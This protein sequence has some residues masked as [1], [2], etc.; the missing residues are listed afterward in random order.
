MAVADRAWFCPPVD[1]ALAGDDVHVWRAALDQPDPLVK[2]LARTLSGDEWARVERYRFERDRRRFIVA[3]GVLRMILG[4][5]LD[6][7]PGRL[8]FGYEPH[9]KPYLADG[10][11][12]G[13]LQFN[14]SHSHELALYAFAHGRR[15]GVD[16]EYQRFVPDAE[17]IV[18][19][20]FSAR[21]KAM[22]RTLRTSQRQEAFLHWWTRKEAYGKAL[23]DGL[24]QRLD[25]FGVSLAPGE[26]ARLLGTAGD[27]ESAFHWS[28][29]SLTPARG[30]KAALAVEGHDWYLCFWQ[31]QPP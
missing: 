9:G 22:W 26:S 10:F 16:L 3:R 28:L 2:Q 1:L 27:P 21:E 17:Q 31:W 24:G 12:G 8:R 4:C 30:Y 20:F 6:A 15:I 14:L 25:Q 11:S 7:D 13:T 29:G 18:A 23:G 5:Y 19:G